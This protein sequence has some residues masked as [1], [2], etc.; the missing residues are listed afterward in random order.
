MNTH[1][2]LRFELLSDATFGR[3]DGVAGWVD[4]EVEHD[5]DGMPYLRGRTLKGLL[6]EEGVNILY[7]LQ[8]IAGRETSRNEQWIEAAERLFGEPGSTEAAQACVACS[9][10]RLPAAV[11]DAVH[12]ELTERQPRRVPPLQPADVLASLTAVRRQTA[13]DEMGVPEKASLRTTR[14]VLRKT[15]FEADIVFAQPPHTAD[16]ALLA[17]CI[18]ALRH[19]G[20]G[21]NRGRGKLHATLHD[22]TG[23]DVTDR[24]LAVLEGEVSA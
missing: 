15:V 8:N 17:A 11:R 1:Y 6:R 4:Q 3:G 21:R 5:A 19:A 10:A 16:L 9:D 24:C 14:V 12:Y 23:G 2:T 18:K 22:D 13:M 7:A 20:T